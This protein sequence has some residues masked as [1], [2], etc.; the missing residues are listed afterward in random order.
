[1]ALKE[2][3]ISLFHIINLS[4]R[5]R[6]LIFLITALT[7]GLTY[8]SIN[9]NNNLADYYSVESSFTKM[10]SQAL[11]RINQNRSRMGNEFILSRDEIFTRF[12]EKITSRE[13]QLKIFNK[14]NYSEKLGFSTMTLSAKNAA[15]SKLL[16]SIKV[17]EPK[18]KKGALL[19]S[20]FVLKMSGN[21]SE[22]LEL[23]IDD[24]IASV[25]Y[26]TSSGLQTDFSEIITISLK[27][28][29]FEQDLIV[30]K[31][32]K[33]YLA[34]SYKKE[35]RLEKKIIELQNEIGFLR[36]TSEQEKLNLIVTLTE[37]INIARSLE[38]YDNN[39]NKYRVT[40]PNSSV[41]LSF[42]NMSDLPQWFLYGQKALENQLQM[43][44]LRKNNDSFIPNL[45]NITIE[46][47]ESIR[48][49][50]EMREPKS[51]NK[52]DNLTEAKFS[53]NYIKLDLER[54]RLE[55]IQLTKIEET[56][57]IIVT[58]FANSTLF[59]LQKNTLIPLI[60]AFFFGLLLSVCSLTIIDSY[61]NF[62]NN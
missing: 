24:L 8:V 17:F 9:L 55:N 36:N 38:V 33:D 7:V 26:S 52:S 27:N 53:A 32:N 41:S 57:P 15:V 47:N 1:M 60:L 46:L 16:K 35:Q 25:S 21:N 12:L 3:S 18:I 13:E 5:K 20:S 37:Q 23:F 61:K 56:N 14:G 54:I 11:K 40:E 48:L 58:Q 50:A 49:L 4:V 42:G 59:S 44:E 31:I 45:S 43:I 2:E 22:F 62:K 34:E 10:D 39:L 28:I 19:A 51:S 29:T 30:I 6:N